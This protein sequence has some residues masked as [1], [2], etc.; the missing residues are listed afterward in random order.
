MK[1][2]W[3][4]K[5]KPFLTLLGI[6]GMTQTDLAALTKL[7][8]GQISAFVRREKP[9]GIRLMNR[10][11]VRLG[12]MDEKMLLF[13]EPVGGDESPFELFFGSQGDGD[14]LSYANLKPKKGEAYERGLR[15]GRGERSEGKQK[16]RA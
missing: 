6:R 10:I 5:T 1:P 11:R 4:I 13:F 2:R 15:V 12:I 14:N 3:Y 7:T 9:I 16:E 8:P